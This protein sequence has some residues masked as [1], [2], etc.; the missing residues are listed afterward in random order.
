M[1]ENDEQPAATENVTAA[2][3]SEMVRRAREAFEAQVAFQQA[4]EAASSLTPAER[5]AIR[6]KEAKRAKKLARTA[7]RNKARALEVRNVIRRQFPQATRNQ[8]RTMAE[9]FVDSQKE[10]QE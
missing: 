9:D 8:V 5:A 10:K 7:K 6:A 2:S 4:V 1:T 3:E